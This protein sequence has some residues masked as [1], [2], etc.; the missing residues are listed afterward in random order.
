MSSDL[1]GMWHHGYLVSP[2]WEGKLELDSASDYENG[3]E[4]V[5]SFVARD[6]AGRKLTMDL[7]P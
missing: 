3:N 5:D 1:G 4:E 2:Q 6:Y 7:D